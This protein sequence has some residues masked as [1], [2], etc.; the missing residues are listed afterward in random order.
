[1]SLRE[2]GHWNELPRKAVES[3]SAAIHQLQPAVDE[4]A[5]AGG[6]DYTIFRGHFQ[7]Q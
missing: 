5:L 2:A 6:L 3:L 4:P 7:P 1:M